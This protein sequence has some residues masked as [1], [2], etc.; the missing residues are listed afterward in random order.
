VVEHGVKL[1]G[2][3]SALVGPCACGQLVLDYLLIT[4]GLF[5]SAGNEKY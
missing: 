2:N 3:R 4:E 1:C 5:G